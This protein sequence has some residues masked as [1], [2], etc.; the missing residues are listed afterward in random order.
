MLRLVGLSFVVS[1][2]V[3]ATPAS[4]GNDGEQD[5]VALDPAL[6]V[7]G[8]K[9]QFQPVEEEEEHEHEDE[10]CDELAD[11]E[12]CGLHEEHDDEDHEAHTFDPENPE[13]FDHDHHAHEGC[14]A[15]GAP[16]GGCGASL[17]LAG[18]ALLG[19]RRRRAP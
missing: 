9:T 13:A 6:T 4:A 16:A 3:F 12:L 18:L 2:L 14:S 15:S 1:L 8:P 19:V 11:P 7:S 17:A 5:H 10:E